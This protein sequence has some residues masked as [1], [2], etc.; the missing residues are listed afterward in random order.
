[1]GRWFE[2]LIRILP[3]FGHRGYPLSGCPGT[4]RW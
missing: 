1:M 3:V 4:W 2:R